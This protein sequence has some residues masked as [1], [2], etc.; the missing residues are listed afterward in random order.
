M[1]ACAHV[2]LYVCACVCVPVCAHVCVPVCEGEKEKEVGM[3]KREREK[4]WGDGYLQL[5]MG[6]SI[7]I[8]A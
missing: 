2:C 5:S 7:K 4:L 1:C 8:G 6:C 3:R